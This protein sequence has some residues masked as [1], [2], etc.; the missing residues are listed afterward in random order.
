MEQ[1]RDNIVNVNEELEY[2]MKR[3]AEIDEDI[4]RLREEVE[5]IK[6]HDEEHEKLSKAL[7]LIID[8]KPENVLNVLLTSDEIDNMYKAVEDVVSKLEYFCE[9]AKPYEHKIEESINEYSIIDAEIRKK[10]E[11]KTTYR[12]QLKAIIQDYQTKLNEMKQLYDDEQ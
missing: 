2:L 12:E 10:Q 1:I 3:K 4:K 9:D 5:R 8:F 11:M 7:R 6:K